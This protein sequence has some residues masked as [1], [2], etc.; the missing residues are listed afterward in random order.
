MSWHPP[1]FEGDGSWPSSSSWVPGSRPQG[2]QEHQDRDLLTGF[3]LQV[4]H[5][6]LP[7]TVGRNVLGRKVLYLPGFF[8][9]GE[10]TSLPASATSSP[11]TGLG[12]ARPTSPTSSSTPASPWQHPVAPVRHKPL[13]LAT[14]PSH[15]PTCCWGQGGGGLSV[16]AASPSHGRS[17]WVC[18]VAEGA[19]GV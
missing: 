4:G 11:K 18:T 3:L 12:A 10:R 1:V 14:K 8:T 16:G 9:Y 17:L 7:P 2:L 13:Q 15:L 5:E 19:V 6:P